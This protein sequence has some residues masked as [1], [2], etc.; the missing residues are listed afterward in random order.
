[1][2]TSMVG[3]A[4]TR[5]HSFASIAIRSAPASVQARAAARLETSLDEQGLRSA[6]TMRAS[7]P[8]NRWACAER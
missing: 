2:D 6:G 4:I 5:G 3:L 1:M 8:D 7:D